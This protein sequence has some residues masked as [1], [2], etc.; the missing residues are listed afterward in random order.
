MASGD[1]LKVSQH[2]EMGVLVSIQLNEGSR[3]IHCD[4][5]PAIV[6]SLSQVLKGKIYITC[7]LCLNFKLDDTLRKIVLPKLVHKIK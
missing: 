6:S 7:R 4:F 5:D 3:N 1:L 2:R